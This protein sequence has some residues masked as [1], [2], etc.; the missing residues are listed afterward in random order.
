VPFSC[1]LLPPAAFSFDR[2]KMKFTNV[3]ALVS[4]LS[5]VSALPIAEGK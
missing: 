5:A 1:S 3:A 4:L 2:A